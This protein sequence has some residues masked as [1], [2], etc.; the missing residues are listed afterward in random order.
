MFG[1]DLRAPYKGRSLPRIPDA[2]FLSQPYGLNPDLKWAHLRREPWAV[3]L[4]L[5][6]S[7]IKKGDHLVAYVL[8]VVLLKGYF[9]ASFF[10]F[11]SAF[12]SFGVLA[13]VFLTAFLL[14]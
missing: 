2:I 1:A 11:F 3:G 12:F 10:S 6:H 7:V 13:D 9:L 4:A 8:Q 14:S 5:S